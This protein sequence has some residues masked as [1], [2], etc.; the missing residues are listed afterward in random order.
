MNPIYPGSEAWTRL[1]TWHVQEL[2]DAAAE[3]R[4]A[5][6]L[7]GPRGPRY[8]LGRLLIAAGQALAGPGAV[9]TA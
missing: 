4:L 7:H 5:R 9:K 2:R 1:V 8:A 6:H 3:E